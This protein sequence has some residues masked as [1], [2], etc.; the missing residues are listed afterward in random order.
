MDEPP[1][2]EVLIEHASAI[3]F[4]VSITFLAEQLVKWLGFN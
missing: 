4:F 2:W 3:T 1:I